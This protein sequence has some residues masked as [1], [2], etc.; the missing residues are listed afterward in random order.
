MALNNTQVFPVHPQ[1]I[2]EQLFP[3]SIQWIPCFGDRGAQY[4]VLWTC[5]NLTVPIDYLHPSENKSIQ[6]GV[7]RAQPVELETAFGLFY[8]GDAGVS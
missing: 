1:L 3:T 4:N 5:A 8:T 7:A 6:I 2:V